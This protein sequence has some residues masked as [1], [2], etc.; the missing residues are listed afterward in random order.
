MRAV[1]V[2][3]RYAAVGGLYDPG[4]TPLQCATRELLEETGLASPE[5]IYLGAYR[6]Q[7]NRGG[8]IL[9]AFYA[10]NSY[11]P[12]SLAGKNLRN[13]H[14]YEKQSVKLLTRQELLDVIV[15]DKEIG[16]AQWLATISTAL[17]YD[18]KYHPVGNSSQN[19]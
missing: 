13:S 12:E 16:E 3:C 18:L 19:P 8:G 6:V 1:F 15:R 7:V 4:E 9:H 14:D 2:L 17:L 10:K 11:T 5:M